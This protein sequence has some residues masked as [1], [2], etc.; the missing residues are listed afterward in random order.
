MC[1]YL[2]RLTGLSLLG[3]VNGD[4]QVAPIM[5]GRGANGKTT[6]IEAVMFALGDYAVAADPDL[7]MART[8]KSIP[9]GAPTCSAGAWSSHRRDQAG[10]QVRPGAAQATHWRG[11]HQSAVHAAGLL[12]LQA[13]ASAADGH[14]PS[15]R[16]STTPPRPY[17][18]GSG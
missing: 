6:Y 5:T 17:G 3:E 14:Q 10:P 12:Q 16:R 9:P 18:G 2:Q 15:A 1:D 11:H 13:V 4:K 8:A 7:L